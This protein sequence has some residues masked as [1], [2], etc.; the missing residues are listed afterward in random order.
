MVK[1]MR[2]EAV[3]H[4]FILFCLFHYNCCYCCK[5]EKYLLSIMQINNCY[6]FLFSLKDQRK[7]RKQNNSKNHQCPECGKGFSTEQNLRLHSQYHT[8]KFSYYCGQCRRGFYK[9]SHYDE[10]MRKHEGR[11]YACEYCPKLFKAPKS[12]RYHLSEHTGKFTFTCDTC[13]K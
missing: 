6:Y 3:V 9:K 4:V 10:H 8:G 13:G 2:C 12:L 1:T 5:L 11:G 7:N